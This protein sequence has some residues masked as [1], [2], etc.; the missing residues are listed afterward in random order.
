MIKDLRD[1]F[2]KVADGSVTIPGASDSAVPVETYAGSELRFY[3]YATNG[4]S[5]LG[6]FNTA[7]ANPAAP[8]Q[9]VTDVHVTLTYNY[10]PTTDITSVVL[11]FTNQTGLAATRRF[12]VYRM[13]GLV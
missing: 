3:V 4:N 1:V 12:K 8:G 13:R 5:V 9:L 2:I 6:A 11:I 10:N 7:K